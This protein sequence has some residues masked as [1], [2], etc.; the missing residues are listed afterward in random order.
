MPRGPRA[1]SA[2]ASITNEPS[3]RRRLAPGLL[4][5]PLL[6]DPPTG[7]AVAG[8]AQLTVPT[9]MARR[10]RGQRARLPG[11]NSRKPHNWHRG[12]PGSGQIRRSQA[13]RRRCLAS[14][15]T[16]AD[17]YPA[18]SPET[19]FQH[20]WRSWAVPAMASR[21]EDAAVSHSSQLQAQEG[22]EPAR[23]RAAGAEVAQADPSA[24]SAAGASASAGKPGALPRDDRNGGAASP[25]G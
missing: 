3:V 12:L 20:D 2:N 8:W 14:S 10:K 13:P 18:S 24:A 15:P 16:F 5:N 17:Q 21:E 6:P 7:A 9:R 4:P 1:G 19:L 11:H 25:G 22:P 23:A